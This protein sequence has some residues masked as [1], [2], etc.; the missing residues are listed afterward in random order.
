MKVKPCRY[1]LVIFFLAALSFS[2]AYMFMRT[3]RP[4][5]CKQCNIL[6][7]DID[8]L[9]ADALPCYGHY[10]N[11][12]SNLCSYASKSLVFKNN[13]APAPWTFPSMFSTIT[14]LYPT[15]HGLYN[16]HTDTLLEDVPTLAE[17]L[18]SAGYQTAYISNSS[19]GAQISK[20]NGGSRGY[21]TYIIDE[22]AMHIVN[23]L[24]K[25]ERPWFI[26]Y[27]LSDLHFPYFLPENEKPMENISRP[28]GLSL[29]TSDFNQ[30]LNDYL[31]KN[32]HEIFQQNTIKEYWQDFN[33][34]KRSDK[35]ILSD[36]YHKLCSGPNETKNCTNSWKALYDTYI[37]SIDVNNPSH[38]AYLR[39]LYDS[40]I[41]ILDQ[42][43]ISL[44]ALLDS[45]PLVQNTIVVIM[46]DHGEAFG[47]H[48]VFS[49]NQDYH[50][51]M[52]HTP[53]I[54]RSPT[55]PSGI[56]EQPTSNMDIFPTIL[57]LVEVQ[58]PQG[59]QGK[60]LSGFFNIPTTQTPAFFIISEDYMGGIVI[61]NQKWL[62]FLSSKARSIKESVLHHKI[63][64]PLE[65]INV[66]DR[67]PRLVQYLYNQASVLRSYGSIIKESKG[68][69]E[70]PK[71]KLS[72]E[73]IKRM[74]EEGYF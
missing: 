5:T 19:G 4:K 68:V 6:L 10:R 20:E 18:R 70:N 74:Q 22:P 12:A 64:D 33:E 16:Q 45:R 58:K 42:R 48:G 73:K 36:L 24:I 60:S 40:L 61:Q 9:R 14:S 50:T 1:C 59:L 26:H 8:S 31:K 69:P 53:L 3:A 35:L 56:F 25:N 54:I 39:L 21:D 17:T 72:P 7:I 23:K 13:F 47:E 46:S 28:P 41:K 55:A 66:A 51:E 67:H 65:K 71:I 34:T 52:F 15:F 2:I 44:Y 29:T 27:H 11:T 43:L 32:Y 57:D 49:H 62:F 37:Q 30:Q 38:T 63:D